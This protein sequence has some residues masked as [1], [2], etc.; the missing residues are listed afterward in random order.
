M[1]AG[2][3]IADEAGAGLPDAL[4]A[5]VGDAAGVDGASEPHAATRLEIPTKAP[6]KAVR[7][8]VAIRELNMALIGL[9]NH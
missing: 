3:A 6:T 4:A 1:L 9:V 5:A 7:D 2:N 8:A